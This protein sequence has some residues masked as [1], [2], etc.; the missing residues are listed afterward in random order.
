MGVLRSTPL[1]SK[2]ELRPQFD[3]I[4]ALIA[5]EDSGDVVD[6]K[7]RTFQTRAFHHENPGMGQ[8]FGNDLAKLT[9]IHKD[10]LDPALT[11]SAAHS[12]GQ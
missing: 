12:G 4:S 3:L 1:A 6:L 11:G 2:A 7:S 9:D 10:G 5:N 8:G